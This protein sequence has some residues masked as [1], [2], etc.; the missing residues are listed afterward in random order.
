M[1]KCHLGKIILGILQVFRFEFLKFSFFEIFSFHP[2]IRH[3]IMVGN[4]PNLLCISFQGHTIGAAMT[5]GGGG[6]SEVAQAPAQAPQ[7]YQQ[8]QQ[9]QSEY[10]CQMELK[11]FLECSQNQSDISLCYG[12]NEA[13]K[14]CRM[15]SGGRYTSSLV[16]FCTRSG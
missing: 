14:E 4:V 11:Q 1:Q 5:G 13:L 9:Q 2:C 12:F 10:P 3:E 6:H 8:P 15:R 7:Q 16:M